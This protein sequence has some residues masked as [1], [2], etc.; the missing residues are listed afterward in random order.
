MKHF[1]SISLFLILFSSL[2]VNSQTIKFTKTELPKIR[3]ADKVVNFSS[4]YSETVKSA[5]QIL[6]KPNAMPSGGDSPLAWAVKKKGKNEYSKPASIRVSYN[7]PI[8][9]AQIGIA[10]SIN[11]GS[12]EKV[13]VFGIDGT[14]KIVYENT[15]ALISEKARMLNI[16]I[17]K[18]E[19]LVK[20]IELLLQPGLVDGYWRGK[21]C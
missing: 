9:V 2:T 18:T 20:E 19:F 11:P 4:Q 17:P 21:R 14:A 5:N 7:D 15:P 8:P 10:E 1:I 16:F 6:G 3:W 13:T 12:I